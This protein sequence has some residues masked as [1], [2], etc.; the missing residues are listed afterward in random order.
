MSSTGG[1][2]AEHR[3]AVYGTLA[4]GR[5]NE[6]LLGALV[7]TWTLGTVRGH[8]HERGWGAASGYPG[9]V[10]D[11]SG[12]H[13][14]V[15]LFTSRQLPVHWDDLDHFEGPGYRRRAAVVH[16]DGSELTAYVYALADDE[17]PPET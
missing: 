7:G 9:I 1:F 4:P 14:E 2:G 3:L 16:C 6:H 11:D 15:H 10:L 17:I 8:L 13:V 5:A 12:P